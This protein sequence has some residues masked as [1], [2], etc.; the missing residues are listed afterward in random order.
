M[1]CNIIITLLSVVYWNIQFAGGIEEAK[2]MMM[3]HLD[4]AYR[5]ARE[6]YMTQKEVVIALRYSFIVLTLP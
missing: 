5:A 2:Q 3:R 4:D 6:L 1:R